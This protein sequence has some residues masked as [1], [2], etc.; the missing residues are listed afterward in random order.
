MNFELLPQQDRL[1]DWTLWLGGNQGRHTL[2]SGSTT[3]N[4]FQ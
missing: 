1:P 4:Q 3:N 2:G